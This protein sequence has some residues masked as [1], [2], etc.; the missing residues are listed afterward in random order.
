MARLL[1]G[2][3]LLLLMSLALMVLLMGDFLAERKHAAELSSPAATP[4]LARGP[5]GYVADDGGGVGAVEF[6]RTAVPGTSR[7]QQA[8]AAPHQLSDDSNDGVGLDIMDEEGTTVPSTD[9]QE[10][11]ADPQ[12][13]SADDPKPHPVA[14]SP[15]TAKRP[16]HT[17]ARDAQSQKTSEAPIY[18]KKMKRRGLMGRSKASR[19]FGNRRLFVTR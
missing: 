19:R 1:T 18:Q 2:M 16:H 7:L 14:L 15:R 9:P 8:D 17:R 12:Q 3:W 4:P 11:E 6:D 10:A 13:L 5:R